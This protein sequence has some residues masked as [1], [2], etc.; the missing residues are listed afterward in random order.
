MTAAEDRKATAEATINHQEQSAAGWKM[1]LPGTTVSCS[2]A[3]GSWGP[4]AFTVTSNKSTGE[5][6]IKHQNTPAL[7]LREGGGAAFSGSQ[8]R[9]VWFDFGTK[10]VGLT[11]G[12]KQ[13]ILEVEF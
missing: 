12:D 5:G 8:R 3:P 10:A 6:S 4:R 7:P 9:D 2:F 1:D 13:E 11:E